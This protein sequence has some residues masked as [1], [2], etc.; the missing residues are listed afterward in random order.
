MIKIHWSH[1]IL[2]PP[3]AASLR[4]CWDILLKAQLKCQLG[5]NTLKAWIII[6]DAVCIERTL[7]GV[8]STVGIAQR[9]GDQGVSS[10][11][12]TYRYS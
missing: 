4:K 12:P 11:N 7:C 10:S 9:S 8:R 1:H 6:Q 2:Y 5:G 3:G